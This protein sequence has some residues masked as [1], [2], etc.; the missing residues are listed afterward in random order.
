MG[1]AVY[2]FFLFS[3]IV[4]FF[5]CIPKMMYYSILVLL[6]FVTFSATQSFEII[7]GRGYNSTTN[8]QAPCGGFNTPSNTPLHIMYKYVFSFSSSLSSLLPLFSF[9]L[10]LP[11]PLLSLPSSSFQHFTDCLNFVVGALTVSLS[12]TFFS[13]FQFLSSPT[14]QIV[15]EQV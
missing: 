9:S 11:F 15:V 1:V 3:Y 12:I 10:P 5:F 4:H 6:F 14:L 13:S 8:G 7:G 2:I